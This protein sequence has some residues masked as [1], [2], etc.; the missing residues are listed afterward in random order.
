MEGET[1]PYFNSGKEIVAA[2]E[3]NDES[4]CKRPETDEL[5]AGSFRISPIP[6]LRYYS[7]NGRFLCAL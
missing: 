4:G 2:G 7:P 5:G 1:K 6:V 3:A